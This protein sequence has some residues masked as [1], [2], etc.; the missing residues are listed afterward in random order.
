MR[1][2]TTPNLVLYNANVLTMDM[3]NPKAEVVAIVN[4]KISFVGHTNKIP[5]IPRDPSTKYIDL[6]GKTVVPGF[7]DSHV[8][9]VQMGLQLLELD[10]RDTCSIGDVLSKLNVK[11]RETEKGKWIIGYGWDETKWRD[12]RFITRRDIDKVS[13]DNPVVLKRICMHLWVLNSRV[14][15]V[16][17]S[18]AAFSPQPSALSSQTGHLNVSLRGDVKEMLK[19]CFNPSESELQNALQQAQAEAV[20]LGITSIHD[21]TPYLDTLKRANEKEK[22][23][24]RNYACPSLDCGLIPQSAHPKDGGSSTIRNPHL[25]KIGSVKIFADGSLGARTAA[26]VEPYADDKRNSGTLIWSQKELDDIVTRIHSAG[27]QVAIHAVGDRAIASALDAIERALNVNPGPDHRHRIEHCELV[28]DKLI[29]RIRYL[30]IVVSA[31]PNFIGQWGNRGGLYERRLGKERWQMINPLAQFKRKGIPM[32]FGSDGMP[33]GPMYGI[34]SCVNHPVIE[35]RLSPEGAIYCYT[36]G[37]AYASF[38]ETKKGTIEVGKLADIVVLSD[39]ITS[40][41]QS[42]IKDVKVIMTIIGGKVYLDMT[43]LV[44][45]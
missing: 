4:D 5:T 42:D 39:D 21:M 11:I 14:L 26:L 15:E 2:Y 43:G 36:Y 19:D 34:W 41:P 24:I 28:D 13:P 23:F 31:Q 10:L 44:S 37:G 22:L 1:N 18:I 27:Q 9:F 7:I 33:F 32:V 16:L 17:H 45:H 3:K 29:S 8:H 40:T 12:G 35:N 20:R 25:L 6:K 38:D 30:N